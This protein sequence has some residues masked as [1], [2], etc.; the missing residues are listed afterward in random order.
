MQCF[1]LPIPLKTN[2]MSV[3]TGWSFHNGFIKTSFYIMLPLVLGYLDFRLLDN[4][5][6][7]TSSSNG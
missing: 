6:N 2:P 5:V 4:D 3:Q 7:R 1:L